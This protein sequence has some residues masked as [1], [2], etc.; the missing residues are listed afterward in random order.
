[1]S[2]EA[3]YAGYVPREVSGDLSPPLPAG[4]VTSKSELHAFSAKIQ[5][6]YNQ[7]EQN[8]AFFCAFF[9]STPIWKHHLHNV[10]NTP[11]SSYSCVNKYIPKKKSADSMTALVEGLKKYRTEVMNNGRFQQEF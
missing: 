2:I 5:Y 1:M 9:F 11:E 3:S 8:K 7:S 10:I 6:M 4:K